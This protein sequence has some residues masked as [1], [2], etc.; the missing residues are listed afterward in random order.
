MPT[1]LLKRTNTSSATLRSF[2][3][4]REGCSRPLAAAT[5]SDPAL[6]GIDAVGSPD[7]LEKQITAKILAGSVYVYL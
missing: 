3:R 6:Y 4:R 5:V 2:H 1:W 7:G